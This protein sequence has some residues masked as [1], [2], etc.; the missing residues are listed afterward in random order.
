MGDRSDNV[1]F[2]IRKDSFQRVNC[3]INHAFYYKKLDLIQWYVFILFPDDPWKNIT[4]ECIQ[5]IKLMTKKNPIER[6][7]AKEIF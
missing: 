5:V 7:S 3:Q 2:D 1:P 6:P 4:P